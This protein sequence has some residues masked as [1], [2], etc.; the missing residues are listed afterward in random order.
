MQTITAYSDWTYSKGK[1]G[2]YEFVFPNAKFEHDSSLHNIMEDV[3][4][5][6]RS[7][8]EVV[9]LVRVFLDTE[10]KTRVW[11]ATA[12]GFI[13]CEVYPLKDRMCSHSFPDTG[14]RRTWCKKCGVPA[15]WGN[16][17]LKVVTLVREKKDAD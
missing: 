2:V 14:M 10:S 8:L 11:V 9:D 16:G 13:D 1:D 17:E 6:A 4:E 12:S 7:K 15:E 3:I 5:E